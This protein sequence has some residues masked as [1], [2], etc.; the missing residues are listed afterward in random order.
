[1][2]RNQQF[3]K[4]FEPGRIGAMEIKNRIVMPAMATNLASEDGYITDQIISY[5]E[6][7]AKGG[8]GLVVVEFSCVEFPRGRPT[9][10]QVSIADDRYLPGLTKLAQAI[11]RHGARAAIQLHH[12]GRQVSS[13]IAYCQ[14]AA[15]SPVPK[16]SSLIAGTRRKV[17]IPHE[18]TIGEI[19]E[20][21]G[22]FGQAAERA[23]RA[24]FDGVEIHG[25]SDYL[26][27]QFLSSA[28]NRRTDRYG[29]KLE[30]RVRFLSE[31]IQAVRASV[32]K[33]YPVW[34]RINGRQYG[35]EGVITLEEAKETAKIIQEEGVDAISQSLWIFELD[36]GMPPLSAEPHGSR[37][38]LATALKS[39]VSVPVISAGRLTPEL[40]EEILREGKS[41][42][43]AIG[44]GL[45]ADPEIPNR[46]R[47]N[48]IDRP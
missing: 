48:H 46:R 3:Q 40:G 44:R 30:N 13:R 29:G 1:M 34:C 32:G 25:A 11:R 39:V 31:V 7:R 18:L 4:L 19:E 37:Q 28:A 27:A 17:D 16:P 20:L 24:G 35:Q 6:E 23:K 9:S 12:G 38:H 21:I 26:I 33:T 14:P 2:S 47:F 45:L 43:I 41:D 42:F 22:L 5:Y 36:P 15:P 10:R 8:V